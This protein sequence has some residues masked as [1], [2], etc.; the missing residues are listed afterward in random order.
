MTLCSLEKSQPPCG[1]I[2][3]VYSLKKISFYL[4]AI[5]L[6]SAFYWRTQTINWI[7]A[8]FASMKCITGKGR[9]KFV[10]VNVL[11]V[12]NVYLQV[13]FDRCFSLCV[14]KSLIIYANQN[15]LTQPLTSWLTHHEILWTTERIAMKPGTQLPI[16]SEMLTKKRV[17]KCYS[18]LY[19]SK[20]CKQV[21]F[22]SHI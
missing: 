16:R 2:V 20:F 13:I 5:V 8:I 4:V 7:V 21:I 18:I 19:K 3:I 15:P 22:N 11:Y 9:T 10:C 1:A 17:W 14:L 12:R 6:S